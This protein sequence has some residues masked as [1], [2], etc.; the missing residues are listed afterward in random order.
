[1]GINEEFL[2]NKLRLQNTQP[3]VVTITYLL[4]DQKIP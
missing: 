4:N 2:M 1:V 3:K